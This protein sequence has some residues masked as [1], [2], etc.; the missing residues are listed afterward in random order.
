[1]ILARYHILLL[2]S[3]WPLRA[4]LYEN[5]DFAQETKVRYSRDSL[6]WSPGGGWLAQGP[7]LLPCRRQAAFLPSMVTEGTVFNCLAEGLIGMCLEGEL[8]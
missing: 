1:M 4:E 8:R 3:S 5:L 6:M 7:G 2:G